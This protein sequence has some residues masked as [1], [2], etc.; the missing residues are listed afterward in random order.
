MDG[1]NGHTHPYRDL[2][3]H[4][5]ALNDRI[6]GDLR[7][8]LGETDDLT[9]AQVAALWRLS[10]EDAMTA[11][12]LAALLQC[13]A[14]TATS[15]VDRLERRGVVERAPHPTDRRAKILRLTAQGCRLRERILR[16]T[17][18]QSPLAHLAPEDRD[19]L[20]ALL[21]R[22]V[23]APAADTRADGGGNAR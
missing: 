6:R 10:G 16:Y 12:E 7:A 2:T 23:Q 5:F 1:M 22:A 20:A 21:D 3:D 8:V 13:D 4:L 9:D 15:M 19:S 17:A 11:R 14:S 18:E